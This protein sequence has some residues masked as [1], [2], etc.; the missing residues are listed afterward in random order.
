MKEKKSIH[1]RQDVTLP[2]CPIQFASLLLSYTNMWFES[3][4]VVLITGCLYDHNLIKS[5]DSLIT[6]TTGL[7]LAIDFLE[8]H[9]KCN[10]FFMKPRE[11]LGI[12][13]NP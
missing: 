3:K 2:S 8:C 4:C 12:I 10:C 5:S 7:H 9:I 13:Q 6:F 1:P 11:Y